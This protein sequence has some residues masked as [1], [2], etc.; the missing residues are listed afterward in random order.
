MQNGS[1]V[2]K[3]MITH[4]APVLCTTWAGVSF[5]SRPAPCADICLCDVAGWV[6]CLLRLRFALR[7]ELFNFVVAGSCDTTAKM[8]V[9]ERNQSGVVAQMSLF[10]SFIQISSFLICFSTLPQSRKSPSFRML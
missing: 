8:W 9:L 3:A 5:L 1:T 4:N 7:Q 10:A 2:P 6:S